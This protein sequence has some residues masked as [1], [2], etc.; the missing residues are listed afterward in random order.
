MGMFSTESITLHSLG[1]GGSRLCWTETLGHP[2][3]GNAVGSTPCFSITG[4]TFA[5]RDALQSEEAEGGT[6]HH[7]G[8]R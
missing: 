6:L 4:L 7:A 8:S 3:H 1:K 2:A 5:A